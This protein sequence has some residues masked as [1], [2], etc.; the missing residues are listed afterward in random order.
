MRTKKILIVEDD[1]K[2]RNRISE[3]LSDHTV[4]YAEDGNQ[5]IT[6]ISSNQY[7]LIITDHHMPNL[8]GVEM[9]EYFDG[10]GSKTPVIMCTTECDPN[11]KSRGSSAGV[12]YWVIK[13]FNILGFYNLIT[14]IFREKPLY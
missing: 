12:N 4:D 13:P 7:D 11:L 2:I 5:G 10:R 8:S 9:L 14:D 1:K 3:M 6:K